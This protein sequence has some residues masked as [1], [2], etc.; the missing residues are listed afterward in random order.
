VI[1]VS[2]SLKR[3][4]KEAKKVEEIAQKVLGYL[5]LKKEKGV[6][7]NLIS[8]S[9]MEKLNVFYKKKRGPTNILSFPS[10][11][12]FPRPEIGFKTLGEIY[13]AI[14]YIK[15]QGKKRDF[16]N[17]DDE[18]KLLIAH[19]I[20]HLLGYNHNSEKEAQKMERKEKRILEALGVKDF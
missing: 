12:D 8:D 5:N 13:L 16:K 20:L 6:E 7:I 11:K 1:K 15:K 10:K 18:L 14:D 9:D 17:S 3:F 4:L 19:G 2:F